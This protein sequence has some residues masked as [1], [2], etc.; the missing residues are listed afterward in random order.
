MPK[1]TQKLLVLL[2]SPADIAID[3]AVLSTVQETLDAWI[4]EDAPRVLLLHIPER[5]TLEVRLFGGLDA[6]LLPAIEVHHVVE[7]EVPCA[8]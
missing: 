2:R 8:T 1:D 7:A 6:A 3:P 5:V 4:R